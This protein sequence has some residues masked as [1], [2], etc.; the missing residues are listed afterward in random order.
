MHHSLHGTYVALPTPFR[1]GR[2]DLEVLEELIE[3][4]A[5]S[6]VEGILISGTT[7]EVP[8]LNDYEHRS[9]IHA[10]VDFSRGRLAVMAGVG[11]N[12]T[13]ISVE[14]AS[15]AAS[16]GVDSLL[17]VTPYYNRPSRRG[18]LLHYGQIAAASKLPL[19]LYNVP[20]RTGVDLLPEVAAELAERHETIVAIKEASGSVERVRQL[21]ETTDLLVLAGDDRTLVGSCAAGAVGT[22]SVIANLAPDYVARIVRH[23]VLENDLERAEALQG[24]LLPLID[25]MSVDVNPVPLKAALASM[26]LCSAEV[27]APLAPMEPADRESLIAALEASPVLAGLQLSNADWDPGCDV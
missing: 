7:G 19:V 15:F 11:T 10:A 20:L 3:R 4:L 23:A 12:C 24:Q 5:Q 2:V 6:S 22:I 13:R 21:T 25:A 17:A 9:L 16:S 27:R 14:L 26:G 1:D 18:L 8:T